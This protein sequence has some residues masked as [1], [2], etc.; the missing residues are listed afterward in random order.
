MISFSVMFNLVVFSSIA[1]ILL[2]Y[3]F[4]ENKVILQLDTRFLLV[5]MAVILCRLLVP[6][7]S[8]L[9]N[10]IAVS[11]VYPEIYRFL[12]QTI[13]DGRY[14]E[15]SILSILK[16]IWFGVAAILLVWLFYSYVIIIK[17]IK[18]YAEIKD[19][20]VL[21]LLEKVNS[22]YKYR[23]KIHL[24]RI[25]SGNTP[26]VFGIWRPYILMPDI[27]VTEKELEFIFA[28]ELKHY[29]RGDLLLKLLCEIFK[30][31]YWWNIPGYFLCKLIAQ[32]QEINVDFS[33]MRK[34]SSDDT[35]DYSSFLVKLARLRELR[36]E[37]EKWLIGFQKEKE[38]L[39]KKRVELMMEN[40]E[41]STKK[42]IASVLLSMFMIGVIVVCPNVIS[43]EAYGIPEHDVDDSVGIRDYR[44]FYVENENGTYDLYYDGV[45]V[46]TIDM[47]FDEKI[48][49]YF[50][51]EEAQ[52][53]G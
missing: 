3:I 6:V 38:I 33:I 20:Q 50:S 24:V 2:W 5:C 10:N 44:I 8:P 1:T 17:K 29:Y 42:T 43:F 9:T 31:V 46:S 53:D 25:D 51:I 28:H 41:V 30:A 40:L 27:E 22:Q 26:C 15:V 18:G 14:G 4:K 13:A 36:R 23:A 19:P 7:E 16:F 39:L 48:P 12:R 49:V 45:Y 21:A 11:T 32:T 37:T 52:K 47:I 34:L 35:L